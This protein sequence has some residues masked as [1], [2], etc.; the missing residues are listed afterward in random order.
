MTAYPVPPCP[1]CGGVLRPAGS[2]DGVR[3]RCGL[4][5]NSEVMFR[6][7]HSGEALD[8]KALLACGV[9]RMIS[10]PAEQPGIRVSE[11]FAELA[12]IT[13]DDRS[14]RALDGP[15][16][17][18]FNHATRV[19][20]AHNDLAVVGRSGGREAVVRDDYGSP[21]TLLREHFYA[22]A[23][24]GRLS[25]AVVEMARFLKAKH[26]PGDL[27]SMR[28]HEIFHTISETC[29]TGEVVMRVAD[30]GGV[31]H[32]YLRAVYFH[33]PRPVAKP[34]DD[35]FTFRIGDYVVW[36]PD[37]RGESDEELGSRAVVGTVVHVHNGR[38]LG[39]RVSATSGFRLVPHGMDLMRFAPQLGSTVD[40]SCSPGVIRLVKSVVD[41]KP[42]ERRPYEPIPATCPMCGRECDSSRITLGGSETTL[43]GCTCVGDRAVMSS[44]SAGAPESKYAKRQAVPKVKGGMHHPIHGGHRFDPDCPKC[45]NELRG[46]STTPKPIDPLDVEYDG[47]KLRTLLDGDAFN[48]QERARGVWNVRAMSPVQ[49]AAVSAHWSAQ[50]RAKVAASKA[51]DTTQVLMPLDAEDCEW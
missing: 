32:A 8:V 23:P 34:A 9:A 27:M 2:T 46:E 41:V 44:I 5:I 16:V 38:M 39:I 36:Y 1:A 14:E 26:G 17:K 37:A 10:P 20:L 35:K 51:A 48:R 15:E 24:V 45:T 7:A 29:S 6:V 18:Q 11:L 47:V 33:L 42:V 3:C 49:R 22:L 50:L 19:A 21:R 28:N 13:W 25:D 30:V 43:Y 12:K 40:P 4:E 31:P